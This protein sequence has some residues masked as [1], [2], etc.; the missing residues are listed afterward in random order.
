[1]LVSPALI[2]FFKCVHFPG[3]K[4]QNGERV[5][6]GHDFSPSSAEWRW[7]W[8]W[9]WAKRKRKSV[10]EPRATDDWQ[11]KRASTEWR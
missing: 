9:R 3:S 1:M 8:R 10:E 4:K 5:A 11:N 7:R 6:D 2:T